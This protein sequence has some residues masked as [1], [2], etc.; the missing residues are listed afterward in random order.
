[1]YTYPMNYW[2]G[3]NIL[4]R[5]LEPTDA[6][7]FYEWDKDSDMGRFID[8]VWQPVSLESQRRWTERAASQEPGD[9]FFFVIENLQG[10]LVGSLSTHDCD[11][12]TGTFSYGV[13]VRA[14]HQRRGYAA[15]A[16]RMVLRYFFEELRYQK[17]TVHA[18]SNNPAS[19]ALH[20]H[21]GFQLEGRLRRTVF[22]GGKY[23]DDLVYGLTV[24]EFNA[25]HN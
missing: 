15:E 19:A 6:A 3:K 12:R 16:I 11:R 4:L 22:D 8:R 5:A 23:L 2:Q 13:A 25:A 14:A 24:E 1:V 20:E 7:A 18:H 10:E 21:L 9:N 17:A